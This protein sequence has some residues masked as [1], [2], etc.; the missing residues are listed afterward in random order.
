MD[1]LVDNSDSLNIDPQKIVVGGDSAG[2][3]LSTCLC[4][5]RLDESKQV[6][7]ISIYSTQGLIVK[8]IIHR[9]K[10]LLTVIFF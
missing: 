1:W 10:H 7:D 4:I 3:N 9:L 6:P 8:A 2:A 5:K